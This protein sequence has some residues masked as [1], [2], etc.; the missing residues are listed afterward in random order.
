MDIDLVADRPDGGLSDF[1]TGTFDR[2][3][4]LRP[5]ESGPVNPKHNLATQDIHVRTARYNASEAALLETALAKN[6]GLLSQTGAL[7][8]TTGKFTGRSPEDKHIVVEETTRDDIWWDGNRQMSADAFETLKADMLEH[9]QEQSVEVQDLVCGSVAEHAVNIRLIAEFSWHALFLR[10]LMRRPDASEVASYV[11]EYTII[12]TPGFLANPDRHGCRSETVIAVSFEQKLVLIAGTEYSGENKKSAF[13]ILNYLYPEKGILPMHCSANHAVGNPSDTAV[14]FGLSGTGKTTLSADT[15]RELIGDDE[16][17]WYDHG[18]FNFEGGCYAKTIRLSQAAEPDIW[19]AVHSFGTVLEN[20]KVDAD[21]RQLDLDDASITE[22]TRAAYSL[23]ALSGASL[24]S[25]GGVPKNVF[26][27]TCDAFGVT[28][29]ICRLS[30]EEARALFLLGFTSKVSGTERGVTSPEPTFSTCFGAP[31]LTRK[32]EVY[33]DLFAAR[34]S[35]SG[36]N[37]WLINTGWTGG[38]HRT[39]SRM[40]IAVTRT[41]LRAAMAG[42]FD[43]ANYQRDEI[44]GLRVPENGPKEAIRYLHPIQTWQNRDAFWSSARELTQQ[45]APKLGQLGIADIFGNAFARAK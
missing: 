23:A 45:I 34:L 20:V 32:P 35:E 25:T 43:N 44:W 7:V 1:E 36:A 39:G 33:S 19:S 37:V 6:E 13:T 12:N 11:P 41:L 5:V 15:D 3:A 26:L 14:F 18:V 38:D 21:T 16:H 31:F 17:G 2:G 42:D 30:A 4:Q 24:S 40:P 28:P 22:N 8:V 10:N 29:P 9:L 27:L